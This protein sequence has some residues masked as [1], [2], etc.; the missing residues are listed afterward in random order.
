M[1][2]LFTVSKAFGK[3]PKGFEKFFKTLTEELIHRSKVKPD[4][5]WSARVMLDN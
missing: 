4:G 2:R 5:L 1:S 3:A